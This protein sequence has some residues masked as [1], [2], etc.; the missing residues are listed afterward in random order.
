[1]TTAQ[2]VQRLYIAYFS[3]PAD[4]VGLAY[5]VSQIDAGQ[6][7]ESVANNFALSPEYASNFTGSSAAQIVNALYVNLFG[8][9]AEPDGLLYW[10]TELT[11]GTQTIGKIALSI[12]L[13]AQDVTGGTQDLTALNSKITASEAFTTAVDS[14]DE[15]LGYSGTAANA[16]A[17]TYLAAVTDAATLATATATAALSASVIAVTSVGGQP[18]QTFTLTA[19]VD[20]IVGTTGNDTINSPDDSTLASTFTSLDSIDGGAGRD[21]LSFVNTAAIDTTTVTSTTV[22]NIEVVNFRTGAGVTTDTT[23]WT[24]LTNLNVTAAAGAVSL[25]AGTSTNVSVVDTAGDIDII[26]GG[27]TLNI[28]G[29]G[30]ATIQVGQ[31]AAANAYTSAT[32]SGGTTVQIS[33]LSGGS[34]AVGDTLTTVSVSGNSGLAT[35]TGDG[36]VN[37][38]LASTAAAATIT[39]ATEDHAL[40]LTVNAVTG[41]AAITDD[42]ATS[43]NLTATGS[44]VTTASN[45]NLTVDKATALAV[46]TGAALT[47]TTT[48]LAAADVLETIT[49]SGAGSFTADVSGISSLTDVDASASTG[50]NTV[51][52]DGSAAT[53]EGGS[54]VDSVTVTATATEVLDGGAGTADVLV[55][56]GVAGTTQ[57]GSKATGFEVL[58]LGALANGS[59]S[60][61]GFSSLSHGAVAADVT[62][63]G[64]EANASLTLNAT[65]NFNTTVS[66]GNAT[67]T[68][69]VLGITVTGSAAITAGT[70]T[71]AGIETINITSDDTASTPAGTVQHTLTLVATSA[72]SI[73]LTGDAGLVLTNTGNTA[74]TSFDA[75]GIT[76]TSG[77]S[78]T[79][80][81]I[82]GSVTLLGSAGADTLDA[83]ATTSS[84][85][86]TINGG[87]GIDTITGGA[88]ADTLNGDGGND[89]I[90]GGA[91][92]DTINGGTGNDTITGGTGADILTGGTGNDVFVYTALNHS[93]PSAFDTITDFTAATATTSGDQIRL[94]LTAGL[95]GGN[96]ASV[97]FNVFVAN[98][99]ALA[100]AA[101]SS[102]TFG[103]N[104]VNVALDS[105][106]GTLYIDGTGGVAGT[107]DGTADLA[108]VLTGVTTVT[109]AAF[110]LV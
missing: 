94:D 73:V 22:K 47:L 17:R 19:G 45:I 8:R 65:P 50:T 7:V 26:G 48:A 31:T 43:V 10:A 46:N 53:Y 63:T 81:N 100:L 97:S 98:S 33:D 82:T 40:N 66:L 57:V 83:S 18:G 68:S 34:A 42:E 59:Y 91:G 27:G 107:S 1:V 74:V 92:V 14:T 12:A 39:N 21:T 75:S 77:V 30:A 58:A 78:F 55:L 67:G 54:G 20:T 93:A 102:T 16:A 49:V 109:T 105:S 5:W 9:A 32:V 35:L 23:A 85:S 44:K 99:G 84:K 108:I 60:A 29:T 90:V 106:T 72:K 11:A 70:V 28:V 79:S 25:T 110:D 15:I 41:G 88:G 3:R 96:D 38:S 101:L 51:T 61:T 103:A 87:S 37:V 13:G 52:I 76:A 95:L 4:P 89:I 36:L 2:D 6:S 86:A 104:I 71:A 69:D 56:N 24:G 62:F 64:V 80:A